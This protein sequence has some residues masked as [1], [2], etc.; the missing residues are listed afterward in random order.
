MKKH[1]L[2]VLILTATT[3]VFSLNSCKKEEIKTETPTNTLEENKQLVKVTYAK[4]A[5]AVYDDA[6]QTALD[7]QTACSN[8]VNAP[9]ENTLNLAKESWKAAREI[10]GQSEIFRFAEGPIDNKDNGPEGLINAWPLDEAYIDYVEGAANSGI[11][12]DLAT[13]PTITFETL[14][15]ANENGSEENISCGYHA[16]EFLLWGQDFYADSPGKRPYTD[17]VEGGTAS[18]QKRR[19]QYLTLCCE[20]LVKSLKQ[21]KDEWVDGQNNYRKSWL[22]MDN[23]LALRKM[24]NSFKAMTGDELSGERIYTAY[25]NANQ[26]DEHSCFSDNT[27]RDIYLNALGLTN[28]Y[29]GKYT[30]KNGQTVSGYSLENLINSVN[31][32]LNNDYLKLREETQSKISTIYTPF[33][34]A[35]VL[36]TERPNVLASVLALQTEEKKILEIAKLF[37]INF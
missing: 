15:N 19:G 8:F 30:T 27:H 17:F 3:I 14:I 2:S 25:K 16:I 7:L 36:E 10:Y 32:T 34:Q 35:I 6:Y 20:I 24:F 11:I 31:P 21:V 1:T 13:Y 26:E 33:D 22:E 23:T 28:L 29:K 18:N 37:G 12:N 4:L 9:S 5:N